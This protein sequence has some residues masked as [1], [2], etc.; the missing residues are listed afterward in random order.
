MFEGESAGAANPKEAAMPLATWERASASL[1]GSNWLVEAVVVSSEI[2][3][4]LSGDTWKIDDFLQIQYRKKMWIL[5]GRK[6]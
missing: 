1:E 5:G 3:T 6:M 2:V 4:N